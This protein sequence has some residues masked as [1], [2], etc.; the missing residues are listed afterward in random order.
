M[1]LIRSYSNWRRYRNTV[2]ELSRLNAHELNDLGI[3]ASE[4]S[5]VARQASGR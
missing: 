4:I 1:N 2:N 5:S 3:M